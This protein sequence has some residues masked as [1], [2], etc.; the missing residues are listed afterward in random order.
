M[1]FFLWYKIDAGK[2]MAVTF[3]GHLEDSFIHDRR[4]GVSFSLDDRPYYNLE[5]SIASKSIN[6][7]PRFD[8]LS[9]Q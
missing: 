9:R 5:L 1:Y 6:L 7:Q 4:Y 8:G 3:M 2:K